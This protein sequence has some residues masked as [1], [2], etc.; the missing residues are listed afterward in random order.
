M[1]TIQTQ[2]T[3]LKTEPPIILLDL[4]QI[5]T[6][7]RFALNIL[8]GLDPVWFERSQIGIYSAIQ[9]IKNPKFLKTHICCL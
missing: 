3:R 7:R 6:D 9:D 2:I 4:P 5:V 1:R 8:I